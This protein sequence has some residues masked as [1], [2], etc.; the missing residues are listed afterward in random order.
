MTHRLILRLS[1]ALCLSCSLAN[2][3]EPAKSAVKP[4]P[5]VSP[6]AKREA[7]ARGAF[8]SQK[9]EKVVSILQG[10]SNDISK[11]SRLMLAESLH[12]LKKY[13]DEIRVLELNLKN[14]SDDFLT[15]ARMADAHLKL[16]NQD[17][18]ISSYR[19]AIRKNKKYM[20]AYQELLYLFELKNNFYEARLILK[21][22]TKTF[23]ARKEYLHKMCRIDSLDGY[24]D[25]AIKVCLEAIFKDPSYPDSYVYLANNYRDAGKQT[26]AQKAYTDA[27]KR[28]PKSEFV[29][30]AAGRF[31]SEKQNHH[32][33]FR[34]FKKANKA[35][36]KSIRA[37]LGL[38]Q[39]ALETGDYR[40]SLNSFT[41]ACAMDKSIAPEFRQA[42]TKL[43]V[44]QNYKWSGDFEA[45]SNLCRLKK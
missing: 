40:T 35:D 22:M 11:P 33:A 42:A 7:A 45:K 1:I 39:A 29:Q 28:F 26:K 21:D 12:H 27:A 6:T 31:F 25:S 41:T 10:H 17:D 8:R 38:A 14:D 23:G 18:A 2:G 32:A 9:Y 30:S 37:L 24:I 4:R 16:G 34:Y 5:S 19:N 13:E 44:S 20:P 3:E 15:Y 43:R 36:K